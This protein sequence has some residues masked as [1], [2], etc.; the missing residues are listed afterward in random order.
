[1]DI[2][3]VNTNTWVMRIMEYHFYSMKIPFLW[4]FVSGMRFIILQLENSIVIKQT[5]SFNPFNDKSTDNYI[6]LSRF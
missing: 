5:N 4:Y 2:V 3:F 6:L 1:M